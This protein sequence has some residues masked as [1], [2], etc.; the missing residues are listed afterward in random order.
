[1][2]LSNIRGST[3]TK[4]FTTANQ[5]ENFGFRM[6]QTP[7]MLGKLVG[8]TIWL[9]GLILRESCLVN[10]AQGTNQ[11]HHIVRSQDSKAPYTINSNVCSREI[12]TPDTDSG[13]NWSPTSV[14][15]LLET[16]SL[17]TFLFMQSFILATWS[18]L[19]GP[20]PVSLPNDCPSQYMHQNIY[21]LQSLT[22]QTRSW[23]QQPRVKRS[24]QA[25][26]S[27]LFFKSCVKL[28][29]L[30]LLLFLLPTPTMSSMLRTVITIDPTKLPHA[31]RPSGTQA[32]R[33]GGLF[34]QHDSS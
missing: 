11:V 16:R 30:L 18:R 29:A 1:M 12:R 4:P 24:F 8:C 25:M 28:I 13:R 23:L 14:Y 32:P 2:H 27:S 26:I 19:N 22:F 9:L 6:L 34:K 15:N 5:R 17:M 3:N 31:N 33:C 7:S 21:G 10:P 20:C